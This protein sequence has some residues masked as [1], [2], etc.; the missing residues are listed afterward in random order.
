MSESKKKENSPQQK[1]PMPK[2]VEGTNYDTNNELA[3]T[4]TPPSG[5]YSSPPIDEGL[6]KNSLKMNLIQVIIRMNSKIEILEKRIN[7]LTANTSSQQNQDEENRRAGELNSAKDELAKKDVE[8]QEKSAEF[9][10][11]QAELNNVTEELSRTVAELNNNKELLQKTQ[12]ELGVSEGEVAKKDEE[13]Q[14]KSAEFAQKQA[15]LNNVAEEL[16]R[17]VAELNN[18]KE[19]L[20]KTQEELYVVKSDLAKTEK[21]LKEKWEERFGGFDSAVK[22]YVDIMKKTIKCE[23]VKN[24]IGDNVNFDKTDEVLKFIGIVGPDFNYALKVYSSIRDYKKN[25]RVE[26]TAEEKELIDEVNAFYKERENC[27]FDVLDMLEIITETTL[28]NKQTM[29]DIDKPADISFRYVE[30]VYVPALRKD[31]SNIQFKACIKGKK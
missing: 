31:S 28:F 25:N 1:D 26:L 24:I 23:S 4:R 6:D 14:E 21:E 7:E 27:D 17:T 30:T 13:L 29:Q 9:A 22:P 3:K 16:S 10:Q 15:E 19:L 5:D 2:T 20:Q 11:K 12:E 18:N 8:L